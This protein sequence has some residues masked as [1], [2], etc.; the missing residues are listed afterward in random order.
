[1][2]RLR[3]RMTATGSRSVA[4]YAALVERDPDEYAAPDRQP[5]DQGDRVLPRPEG[6]GSPARHVIPE[7]SARTPLRAR[8]SGLDR[9]LL[10]GRGGVLAGDHDRRGA[11]RPT[12][13]DVRIFATDVDAA[14]IAFARR[15]VYPAGALKGV[16]APLRSRYFTPAGAGFEVIKALRSQIV[17]GE[18]DLG[19]RVPFPRIDLVLCRN[20]LIY[21]TPPLQRVA[22]ET[23]A[24]SLRPDGRLVL[25]PSE[26]VAAL[27]GPYD[28]EHARLRI[29]RRLPG[30]QPLPMA[31]PKVVPTARDVGIPLGSRDPVDQARRRSGR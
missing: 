15:G 24:Y 6:L 9:G 21:F 30:Q 22:L 4:D 13:V 5:A 18:H 17:F 26:T 12:A 8:A 16:P 19:A 28:E 2:R 1:M 3:G 11:R 10:D 25:G 27:P 23:F 29:Y 20:V 14:A 7:L 31:W